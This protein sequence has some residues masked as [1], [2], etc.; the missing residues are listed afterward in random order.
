MLQTI[1]V[2]H[3]HPYP[4]RISEFSRPFWA[5][6]AEGRFTTTRSRATGRLTFPPK[7]ISPSD[8]TSDMEWVDLSGRGTIYSHTTIHAAPSAFVG[9]LPYSVCIVDLDEGLRMATRFIGSGPAEIGMR[10]E[11]VIVR[12][13]D[14]L[15]YAVRATG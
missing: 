10:V 13:T 2:D 15:S 3:P 8:W 6:L 14:V 12:H 4:A 5:A 1:D 11:I 7:P 9:E